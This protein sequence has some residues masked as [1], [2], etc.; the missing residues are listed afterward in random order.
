M[1][2]DRPGPGPDGRPPRHDLRLPGPRGRGDSLRRAGDRR[3]R[4]LRLD[5]GRRHPH[6][7]RL[8]V[9]RVEEEVFSAGQRIAHLGS[10]E[11]NVEKDE[12]VWSEEIYRIF[13]LSRDRFDG[14]YEG[15]L[16][17]VHAEDREFVR[18][19]VSAALLEGKLFSI[20]Y[21][22]V[23]PD[24]A[25]RRIFAQGEVTRDANGKPVRMAG[26]VLDITERRQAEEALKA[27]ARQQRAAAELGRAALRGMDL[28]SLMNE[29]VSLAAGTLDVEYAKVLEL[30]PERDS[31]RLVAGGGWKPGLVGHARVPAGE[32]SQAGDGRQRPGRR[33]PPTADPVFPS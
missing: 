22:I 29:A 30:L 23:Q 9:V 16:A 26:T 11:W 32:D 10:W 4:R 15:F 6:G 1:D 21:R 12:I 24:K 27:R 19:E 17:R 8:T 2:A 3:A 25:E 20:D 5:I 13:G 28:P 14:T 18:R 7:G 31:L 33:H